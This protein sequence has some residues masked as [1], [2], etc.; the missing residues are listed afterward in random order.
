MSSNEELVQVLDANLSKTE[1]LKFYVQSKLLCLIYLFVDNLSSFIRKFFFLSVPGNIAQDLRTDQ[2]CKIGA[3]T[4][5]NIPGADRNNKFYCIYLLCIYRK[6]IKEKLNCLNS[7]EIRI[8][9]G[10]EDKKK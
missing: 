1:Y 5:N 9:K 8:E 3:I 2:A 7:H 4:E 6:L 10:V